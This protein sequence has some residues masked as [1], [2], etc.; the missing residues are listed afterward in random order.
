MTYEMSMGILYTRRA[1]KGHIHHQL[2]AQAAHI[3]GDTYRHFF[4]KSLKYVDK[5]P[6]TVEK[7]LQLWKKAGLVQMRV[8]ISTP[9]YGGW[10]WYKSKI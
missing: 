5:C 8:N 1:A 3:W 10:V 2:Y 6:K 9:I 7:S 4:M